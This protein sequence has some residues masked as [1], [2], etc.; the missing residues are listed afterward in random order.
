MLK[1]LTPINR[2]AMASPAISEESV[3]YSG[4]APVS[5]HPRIDS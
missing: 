1:G 2:I 3:E 4:T 5:I